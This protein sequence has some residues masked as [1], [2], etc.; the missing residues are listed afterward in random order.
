MVQTRE[1]LNSS[2]SYAIFEEMLRPK[3]R[4]VDFD[5]KIKMKEEKK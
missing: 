5:K 2:E 1:N 3:S 4:F